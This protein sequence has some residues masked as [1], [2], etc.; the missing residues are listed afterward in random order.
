MKAL[1]RLALFIIVAV[2]VYNYFWGTEEEKASSEKVFQQVKEV[3]QSIGDLIK[4]EREKFSEGKYD[5]AFE[6]LGTTYEKAKEKL[7]ENREDRARLEELEKQKKA[8]EKEA[9]DLEQELQKDEPNA[10]VIERS[11]SL[12]D[13]IRTLTNDLGKFLKKLMKDENG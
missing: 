4:N 2:L 3:G 1:I 9:D 13:E 7:G 11:Q 8:L 10:E 5:S 12:E 6:K